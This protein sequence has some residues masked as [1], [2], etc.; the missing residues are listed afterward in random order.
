MADTSPSTPTWTAWFMG[1][2]TGLL[3]SINTCIIAI[4]SAGLA[5][6]G[7]FMLKPAA[8]PATVAV[9]AVTTQ[10]VI[11]PEA[12]PATRTMLASIQ[13]KQAE[14]LKEL[15]DAKAER[16]AKRKA[17]ASRRAKAVQPVGLFGASK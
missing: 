10:P 7:V 6:T 16:E 4:V 9:K 3:P 15:Q 8:P 1:F 11:C 2:L 5:G 12:D 13:S 14:V 17:A